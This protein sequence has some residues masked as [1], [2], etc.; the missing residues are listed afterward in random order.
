LWLQAPTFIFLRRK[1]GPEPGEGME[2]AVGEDGA[3]PVSERPALS[4]AD[5]F[6][7]YFALG[8]WLILGLVVTIRLLINPHKHTVYP[9]FAGAAE[10]WWADQPIY[11]HYPG[12]DMFRCSPS[13][14]VFMTP[15]Q[16]LGDRAGQLIWLWLNIGTYL[17]GLAA[18]LRYV[19][20]TGWSH[21]RTSYFLALSALGAMPCVNNAQSNALV[22]GLLLLAVACLARE[23]CWSAA[24]LLAGP[25]LLKLAPVAV[26]LLFIAYRPRQLLGRFTFVLLVGA[27][28]PFLTR[29]AN[30]VCDQYGAWFQASI[31]TSSERWP[32]YRD[33]WTLW[34]VL[35]DSPNAAPIDS[36][37][38]R[39]VQIMSALA[40]LAWCRWQWHRDSSV[41]WQLTVTLA[42]GLAWLMLFGP[43]VEFPSYVMLTPLM[44]WAALAAEARRQGR[45]LALVALACIVLL[46]WRPLTRTGPWAPACSWQC[47]RW[48]QSCLPPG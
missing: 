28:L 32:G 15:F 48:E 40:V 19:L 39:L 37:G 27:L 26:A 6:W 3:L 29:P 12:L 36:A 13:F 45:W 44:A 30:V 23:R 31:Q 47:C 43:A 7:R 16:L 20:P 22:G 33:G 42:M 41:R 34:T 14:A 8:Q 25:V 21:R 35:S 46:P 38:Y 5:G 2:S 9:V 4:R 11:A 10:H 24:F 17:T 1:L 18:F